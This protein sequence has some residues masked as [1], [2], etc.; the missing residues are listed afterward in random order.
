MSAQVNRVAL[1]YDPVAYSTRFES[2][3]NQRGAAVQRHR[4][5]DY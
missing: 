1:H 3:P 2:L 5:H 4:E